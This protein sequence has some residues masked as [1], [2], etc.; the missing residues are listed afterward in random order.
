[1]GAAALFDLPERPWRAG[2]ELP[3]GWHWFYFNPAAPQSQLGED[4]HPRRGEF[5]PPVP[6]PRRMWA[7]GTLTFRSPLRIGAA[8]ARRSTVTALEE[9]EGRTGRLVFVTVRHE[10]TGPGGLAVE[11]EQQLVYREA[12][13]PGSRGKAGEP[14]PAD[15]DWSET[16]TP[17]AVM[18]FRF[19]A[20]TFN[21]HR[22]HY[23]HPYATQVEGYPGLVVHAPLIALLL[24]Q[25]AE[26]HTGREPQTFTFQNVAPLFEGQAITIAGRK[27]SGGAST[28]IWAGGPGGTIATRAVTE[29]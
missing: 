11:E 16:F 14:F 10:I 25:A 20:L 21:G 22:I 9:K 7:G 23:D 13:K 5:L 4:G 3:R 17:D 29:W 18:L 12:A 15:V 1:M 2:D 26:R 19:S 6:L 8:A 24:L 27:N 28:E